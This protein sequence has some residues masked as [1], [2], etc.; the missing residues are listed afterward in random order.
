MKGNESGWYP[1]MLRLTGKRCVVVGGGPVAERKVCSLLDAGADGIVVISDRLTERLAEWETQGRIR[2][3]HRPYREGDIQAAALVIAAT[4]DSELNAHIV[5]QAERLRIWVNT[6]D[7]GP[8][9]DFVTPA[10]VRR[11]DL[12]VA[13][14]TGGASP[15]LAARLKKELERLLGE[16]YEPRLRA[17]RLLRERLLGREAAAGGGIGVAEY[18]AA[19][20]RL[21]LRAAAED[22]DG[23]RAVAAL[24]PAQSGRSGM[25]GEADVVALHNTIELHDSLD[26]WIERLSGQHA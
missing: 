17:L 6:A 13:L 15:A 21:I 11:G 10:V 23:W 24:L 19:K 18:D 16:D 5:A 3:E 2:A 22:E 12:I 26:Q 14:T 4:N 7:D 20:R 25:A 1:V 9:G 8:S